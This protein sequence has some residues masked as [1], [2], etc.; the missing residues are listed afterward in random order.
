MKK[1][2]KGNPEGSNLYSWGFHLTLDKVYEWAS[3]AGLSRQFE[4]MEPPLRA[5]SS[6]QT[7]AAVP[8]QSRLLSLL[9]AR[10]EWSPE[11]TSHI[12]LYMCE[13]ARMVNG[14]SSETDKAK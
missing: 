3:N 1:C 11:S 2:C 10:I 14:N 9:K 12:I 7:Q 13:L 8:R 5:F 4:F 6:D